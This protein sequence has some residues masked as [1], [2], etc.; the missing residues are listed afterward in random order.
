[1]ARLK[2]LKNKV[3]FNGKSSPSLQDLLELIVCIAVNMGIKASI[4]V[5]FQNGGL[6]HGYLFLQSVL[7]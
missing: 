4:L 3:C 5:E 2:S 1:M 6:L 7:G